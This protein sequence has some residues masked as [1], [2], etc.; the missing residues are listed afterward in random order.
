MTI[1]ELAAHMVAKGIGTITI[2]A[3]RQ[4]PVAGDPNERLNRFWKVSSKET[5]F[6]LRWQ[7]GKPST[8]LSAALIDCVGQPEVPLLSDEELLV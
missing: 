3:P 5:D 4:S 8:S 2:R 6:S 7:E 1:E